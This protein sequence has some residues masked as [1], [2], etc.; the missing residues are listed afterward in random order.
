MSNTVALVIKIVE[1]TGW[2]VFPARPNK[3][4]YVKN[5]QSVATNDPQK[6]LDLFSIHTDAMIGL[7]TGPIN[8]ISVV[9]FDIRENYDG[10]Q[11]FREEGFTLPNTVR[12]STPSGGYH[13]YFDTGSLELNNSQ[14]NRLGRGVDFKSK[15]GY[16]ICPP[17]TSL[18]GSYQWDT[19]FVDGH[20][21]L[22]KLPQFI[23]DLHD[24]SSQIHNQREEATSDKGKNGFDWLFEPIQEGNRDNELTRRCGYLLR[25]H[26]FDTGKSFLSRINAACCTPPLPETQVFKICL[27]I[28]KREGK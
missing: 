1:R 28:A 26:D 23:I 3:A 13:Y 14:S 10:L 5:W 6:L 17:S 8:N 22:A 25:H 27:S 12:V 18:K 9:D 21:R 15:G 20:P 24:P 2:R 11:S 7:P 19:H 16:V 4:P